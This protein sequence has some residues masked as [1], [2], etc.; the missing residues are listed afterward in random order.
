MRSHP[1]RRAAA[2]ARPTHPRHASSPVPFTKLPPTKQTRSGAARL[3]AGVV[4][5]R[6]YAPGPGA[7]RLL[8]Y[9]VTPSDDSSSRST[10]KPSAR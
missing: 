2:Q 1:P 8:M 6:T 9:T 7:I 4:P 5:E 10:A 3:S